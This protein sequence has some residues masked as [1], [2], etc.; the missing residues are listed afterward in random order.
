MKLHYNLT[1]SDR[2]HLVETI[3][4]ITGTKAK[5]LGMPS[6]AYQVDCYTIDKNGTLSGPDNLDLEDSLH[7]AGFDADGSSREYD[8]P[9]NYESGLGAMRALDEFP[10][11][12]QHH[13]VQYAKPN[14]QIT[15]TMQRQIDEMIAFEDLKLDYREEFGLGRTRRESFQGENGMQASDVPE[16]TERSNEDQE[17]SAKVEQC[18][19]CSNETGL[20]IT[21]PF[22]RASYENLKK[23][24]EAKGSL[25]CKALGIPATPIEFNDDTISFPWFD[26]MP[27][28][29]EVGAYSQFIVALSAMSKNQSRVNAIDKEVENEKYAFRC[30]LN[31]LGFIGKVYKK[32]RKI[33][34][35][36]LNGSSAFKRGTKDALP[37]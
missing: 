5:Y 34:L 21:L 25:I 10:D 7:L 36:N 9:D 17:G 3:S 31:R 28:P 6:A 1:G 8:E 11:I 24:L 32:E 13:P 29:D 15:E 23:L 35:R 30:F 20:T 16:F 12:D 19:D 27:A 33:L 26:T 4:K 18:T 14:T 37:E 2:K 22:D